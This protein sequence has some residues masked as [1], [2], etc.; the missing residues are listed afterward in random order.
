MSIK[1]QYLRSCK[2]YYSSSNIFYVTKQSSLYYW[3]QIV[4]VNNNGDRTI[5]DQSNAHVRSEAAFAYWH[6]AG[7]QRFVEFDPSNVGMFRLARF[8]EAWAVAFPHVGKQR[9][10]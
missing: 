2:L 8:D 4:R 1:K 5:I 3:S 6:A 10:L 7:S 9:E